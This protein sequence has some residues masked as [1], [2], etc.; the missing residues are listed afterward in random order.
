MNPLI[1]ERHITKSRIILLIFITDISTSLLHLKM[2]YHPVIFY[3][4]VIKEDF[5]SK[6]VPKKFEKIA[7]E[8]LIIQNKQGLIK[9]V[10]LDLGK[11]WFDNPR[12]KNKRRI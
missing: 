8:Y 1:Q 4:E 9:P 2:Y 7:K 10:L 12:E 11:V 5:E 6:Y 3:D